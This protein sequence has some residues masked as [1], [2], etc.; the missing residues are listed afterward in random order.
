MLTFAD[1]RTARLLPY[2]GDNGQTQFVLE[3][4]VIS[5]VSIVVAVE[6][7]RLRLAMRSKRQAFSFRRYFGR[8]VRARAWRALAMAT[9]IHVPSL[10]SATACV[11][12]L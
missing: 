5:W 10:T 4:L 1:F 8:K 11:R 7:V 9:A 2:Q 12:V 3:G 6:V